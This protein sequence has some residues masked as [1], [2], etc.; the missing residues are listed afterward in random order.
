MA[1][2]MTLA[3]FEQ[4]AVARVRLAQEPDGAGNYESAED[5]VRYGLR[6]LLLRLLAGERQRCARAVIGAFPPP[7]V[8]ESHSSYLLWRRRCAKAIEALGDPS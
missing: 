1:E 8:Y 4:A 3:E 6:L 7:A 5:I 2:P